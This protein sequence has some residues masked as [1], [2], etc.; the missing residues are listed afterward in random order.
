MA[1]AINWTSLWR[2]MLGQDF[3]DAIRC[4]QRRHQASEAAVKVIGIRQKLI[5]KQGIRLVEYPPVCYLHR[6][7]ASISVGVLNRLTVPALGG[8]VTLAH[9]I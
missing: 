6:G 7:R 8:V 4:R 2:A 9:S 5:S 1:A 3:L